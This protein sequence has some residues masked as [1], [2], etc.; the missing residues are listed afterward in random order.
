MGSQKATGWAMSS[1]SKRGNMSVST[2]SS[3][4]TESTCSAGGLGSTPK[5]GKSPGEGDGYPPPQHSCL[6]NSMDGD[7]WPGYSPWGR[8]ESN[9]TEKIT[10][11]LPT[12]Y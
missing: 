1:V 5:V 8:Q 4:G 12:F 11:L 6:E 3:H 2:G 9:R 7:A 10:L